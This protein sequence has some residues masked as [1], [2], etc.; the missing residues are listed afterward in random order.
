MPKQGMG[1][2]RREQILRSA[3]KLIAENGFIATTMRDL[4]SEA[5]V[6]TGMVN[7]WFANK[8]ELLTQTLL[9]VS[10]SMQGRVDAALRDVPPGRERLQT[11]V[12]SCLPTDEF[13][14]RSWRV[15]IAAFAEGTRSEEMR[16]LIEA[17][18]EPWHRQL[19]ELLAEVLPDI[20]PDPIPLAWQ[21]DAMINGLV[22]HSLTTQLSL[23][24]SEMEATL[25]RLVDT[26]VEA[27]DTAS[28]RTR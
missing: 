26:W 16:K 13:T 19:A 8:S 17:R 27:A 9:Y 11:L 25:M 7:H 21:F 4:A 5:N 14:N 23:S 15:W 10:E 1:P 2:I 12:R 20:G 18:F 24:A 28:A 3:T 22:I 6:S